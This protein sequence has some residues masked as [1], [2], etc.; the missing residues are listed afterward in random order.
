M[1][2]KRVPDVFP[3]VAL[4][5]LSALYI[6]SAWDIWWYGGSLGQRAMVQAYPFWAFALGAFW[7]WVSRRQWRTWLF[8]LLAVACSYLNLWWSH[9]AHRGGLFVSEQMTRRYMLKILGKTEVARDW[10]KFLDTRDEFTGG[11]RMDIRP[12][13]ATDF[14]KDTTAAITTEKPVSGQKSLLLNQEKQFSPEFELPVKPGETGWLRATATF[15]CEPKEWD[16][17]AMTQ[18]L[19]RFRQGDKVIKDRMVRL[20]RHVD[21]GEVKTLFFDTKIPD[22]PFDRVTVLFWNAGSNKTIRIDFR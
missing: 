13:F 20:Q 15:Q 18:F 12:I 1:L 5:C 7:S 22:K 9:Q 4:Y 17:W 10:L 16:W 11:G 14:E 6:T 19:V 8:V 21:G 2:R 3:T